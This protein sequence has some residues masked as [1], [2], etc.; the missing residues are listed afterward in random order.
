MSR[1][2]PTSRPYNKLDYVNG[3]TVVTQET[4]FRQE[5]MDFWDRY[6]YDYDDFDCST[7]R[8]KPYL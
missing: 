7:C 3:R 6:L 1:Y 4:N 8:R 2:N 5:R